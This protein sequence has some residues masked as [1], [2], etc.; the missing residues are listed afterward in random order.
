MFRIARRS[1]LLAG[2]AAGVARPI[3]AQTLPTIQVAKDATCPC[4]EGWV[5]YLRA[6]GF[7]VSVEVLADDALD[8]LKTEKG[9]P[10][11]ARSC[12]TANADGFVLEGHVPAPEIRR[13]LAERP[14]AI[15]LAVPGMPFGSP[16]MG[17]EAER[18]AYDVL[19]IGK[20]GNISV[21]AS[22][23]AAA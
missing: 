11:A 19:L 7:Q 12:H 15:G 4:C 3:A 10:D 14:A 23:P 6:E 13:L 16:G 8:A 22:Y 1:L 9:V 21:F 17:P 20:D 2:L 5:E 18:E